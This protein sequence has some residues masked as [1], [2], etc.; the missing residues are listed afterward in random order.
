MVDLLST[1]LDGA[2]DLRAV[3]PRAILGV[4]D[5]TGQE[6]IDPDSGREIAERLGAGS[7]VL[8]N[9]VEVGGR[10]RIN[11]AVYSGGD[12]HPARQGAVEG[13]ATDIFGLLDGLAT[14]LVVLDRTGPGAP[15]ERLEQMT[16]SSFEALK[17]Y[18]QGVS[19]F[20][21]ARFQNAADELRL[22]VN[23]DSTFSLAWY[24]L[25]A[26]ADWLYDVDLGRYAAEKA[27]QNAD[28]LS[29]RGRRLVEALHAGKTGENRR[30]FELYRAFVASYPDDVEAWYQLGE[31]QFHTGP[32]L[33]VRPSESATAWERLLYFEP[34][35]I[36]ALI[37]LARIALSENDHARLDSMT[38]R[39]F[40]L[41]PDAERNLELQ[42]H[43]AC[44]RGDEAVDDVAERLRVVDDD[45][46]AEVIWS[47]ASFRD[48]LDC[49][50]AVVPLL[51]EPSR[52][53]EAR[54][55]GYLI[56]GYLEV[57]RGRLASAHQVF[58]MATQ[59]GSPA[60]PM[61]RSLLT[62]LPFRESSEDEID[63]SLRELRAWE[64]Y[65]VPVSDRQS[66]WFNTHDEVREH[67]RTFL[68]GLLEAMR[69]NR[70]A[71]LAHADWL[72]ASSVPA[73]SPTFGADLALAIRAEVA[74]S[75]GDYGEVERLLDQQ[76]RH[77]R[78]LHIT[79]ST[80]FA[81]SRER[82]NRGLL[83]ERRNQYRDAIDAMS[84]FEG[85]SVYDWIYVAPSHLH[86][87]QGYDAL[88]D[89]SAAIEHYSTFVSLWSDCDEEFRPVLVKAQDRLT[90]LRSQA[91]GE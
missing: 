57:A 12:D 2:G 31:L 64:P 88:G 39:V 40:E 36:T 10:L 53:G 34:D 79:N 60:V 13:E 66:A 71:A 80:F 73:F 18:L 81:Q 38:S 90:A 43:L 69:N 44:I 52:S 84:F 75:Q 26:T 82:F 70:T 74:H 15:V 48:D 56:R 46:L 30:A 20:R 29:V 86:R 51:I 68:M 49:A 8:G 42:S 62:V 47:L 89:R 19:A 7:F 11:S 83:L 55:L 22:A 50:S 76:Q 63:A 25:S 61:H 77:V 32:F 41:E 16:T 4:V 24:Q 87:A 6:T 5:Q 23:E 21:A 72:D 27:L 85:Y 14:Q 9:I 17:H 28:N 91:S 58:D 35:Q 65:S 3:D 59:I 78:F 45:V 33:G 54:A 37:H 67:V 1:M